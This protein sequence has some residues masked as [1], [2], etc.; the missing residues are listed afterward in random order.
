MPQVHVEHRDG[1]AVLTLDDPARRN[2]LSL[3][4]CEQLSSAVT[5]AESDATVG[6]L[7]VTGNPPA[8]CAGADL[9]QLGDSRRDGLLRIYEGFL[10]V[11]RSPLPTIAAVNGAAVGAGM[12]L[13][14][15]C[16]LRLAG[17]SAR[18]EDRFL[19]LGIHPGG[20]HTWMMR[21]AVGPQTTSAAVLFG[22]VLDGPEA[23]RVG[24][25]WRCVDDEA[26]LDTAVG[27]AARAAAAPAELVRRTKA[28]I[29][30]VAAIDDHGTA[31]ERELV[32]QLWSMDQPAFAERLAALRARIT[33]SRP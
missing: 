8:F 2:A 24:L 11:A 19:D 31:V 6:A 10:A 21:R 27:L 20:G 30:A 4:L 1:V 33:T 3:E 15:A 26:L 13:A 25:V 5:A 7:V 29:A 22:E 16:D 9:T 14:L 32:D 23:E 28:T 18:F 12:N 17:T